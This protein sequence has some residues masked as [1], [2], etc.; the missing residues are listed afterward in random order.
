VSALNHPNILTVHGFGR[1]ESIQFFSMEY[2]DGRTLRQ[3]MADGPLAIDKAIDIAIQITS[4]LVTAHTNGIV[5]C[6]IK[7]ENI[8]VRHD[9]LVKVLDFGIARRTAPTPGS[10]NSQSPFGAPYGVLAGTPRYMSPEQARGHA[11]DPGS[12]LFSLGS[13]LYEMLAGRPAFP[14]S[15]ASDTLAAVLGHN[16]APLKTLQPKLPASLTAIVGRAL[17]KDIRERYQSA[18]EMLSDLKA[19]RQGAGGDRPT[20]SGYG[21]MRTRRG[22]LAV[23]GASVILS[24][25]L[26]AMRFFPSRNPSRGMSDEGRIRSLAVLPLE[27][28]SHSAEQAYFSDGMTEQLIGDLSKIHQLRIISRYS[29]MQYKGS[30]KPVAQIAR[31][32]NVDALLV[33][34]VL[35]SGKRMQFTARLIQAKPRKLYG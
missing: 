22:L 21:G 9:G 20:L 12:D 5:H 27:D 3:T 10:H 33:G 13:V 18:A 19:V 16:P 32:L 7:P 24:V 8:M 17:K 26:L 15:T 6:D 35:V 4:A 30:R 31:E 11:S 34:S 2:V 23:C 28:L 1:T 14:G 25:L 29:V